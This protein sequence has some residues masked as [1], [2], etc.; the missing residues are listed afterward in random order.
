MET[1]QIYA[2]NENKV[3]QYIITHDNVMYHS[4]TQKQNKTAKFAIRTKHE[5]M[6]QNEAKDT[7]FIIK[8]QNVAL[9]SK[10]RQKAPKL[11]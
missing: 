1:N 7:Q 9:W 3:L 11:L 8:Y 2:E 5:I 6:K 4:N 10:G